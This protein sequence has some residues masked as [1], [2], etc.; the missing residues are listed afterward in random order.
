MSRFRE[1]SDAAEEEV[2]HLRA[3]LE[4][5]EGRYRNERRLRAAA[6]KSW[7]EKYTQLEAETLRVRR[8]ADERLG[9]IDVK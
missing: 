1:K 8:I 5:S 4:D 9:L 7:S 3:R 6:E 2:V